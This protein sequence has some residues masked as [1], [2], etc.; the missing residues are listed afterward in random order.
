M[1]GKS[2]G[3]W[4]NEPGKWCETDN[5]LGLETDQAT[6]FWRETH[7]G[8]IRDSGHFLAFQ[9][10]DAFTAELRVRGDF[11]TLYDQA[12][13]MVR[14]DERR[15]LKA[16]IEFS[17]G[18]AMLS[19]V[20]TNEQSDWATAPYEHDPSDFRLRV[21]IAHGVLRLQ[22]SN[23]GQTWPLMRLAPFARSSSYLVGPMACTPERSGLEVAFSDFRLAP[24][25]GKELHDLG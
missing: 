7:Y 9:A 18:R 15:W 2:A 6:D 5:Y 20:L 22:A 23:D 16:G 8:F 10:G 21:T 4:L 25:L 14:I 3:V 19:S 13:L 1:F 24:P 12:G 17:D 11:K